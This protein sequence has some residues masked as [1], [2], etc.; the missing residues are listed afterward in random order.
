MG[1]ATLDNGQ[2]EVCIREPIGNKC[3]KQPQSL[4]IRGLSTTCCSVAY[5]IEILERGKK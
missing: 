3:G 1:K 5:L 2:Q 4:Y